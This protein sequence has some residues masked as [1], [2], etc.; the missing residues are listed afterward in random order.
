MRFFLDTALNVNGLTLD[1]EQPG[2]GSKTNTWLR[3]VGAQAEGGMRYRLGERMYVEPLAAAAFVYTTFEQISLRGGKVQP[4]DAQSR[5][6]ALGL[7]F[8]GDVP[9]QS[10]NWSYF[11]AGRAWNEFDGESRIAVR[12]PGADLVYAD[13][14]SGTFSEF[15]AG[16]SLANDA[17]TLSGFV[18]SGVKAQDGYSAVDLSTGVRLRW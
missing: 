8:G 11:L 9:G 3:S 4:D 15:E 14:F 6:A 12:N 17:G 5:R 7:R 2:L 16:L 18:T 13:D 1:Y 10:V